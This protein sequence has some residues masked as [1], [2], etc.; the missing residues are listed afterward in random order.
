MFK[1]KN[2]SDMSYKEYCE[3][4]WGQPHKGWTRTGSGNELHSSAVGQWELAALSI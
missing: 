3:Q 1:L 2:D 4:Q